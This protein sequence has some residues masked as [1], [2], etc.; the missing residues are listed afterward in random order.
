[1]VKNL[2]KGFILNIYN[3]NLF[4]LAINDAIFIDNSSFFKIN[5]F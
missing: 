5:A 1:M 4:K 2:F 3:A